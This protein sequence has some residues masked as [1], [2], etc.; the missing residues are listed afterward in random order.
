MI[1]MC[2]S[3]KLLNIEG[4]NIQHPR[5]KNTA[6]RKRKMEHEL[7]WVKQCKNIS[8]FKAYHSLGQS[9]AFSC[10]TTFKTKFS[11]FEARFTS[12]F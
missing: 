10:M 6:L 5:A 1:I 11:E 12:L 2:Y 8:D 7:V 4:E 3:Y 9:V